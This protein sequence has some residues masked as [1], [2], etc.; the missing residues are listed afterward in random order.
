MFTKMYAQY[1]CQKVISIFVMGSIILFGGGCKSF[2]SRE[3]AVYKGEVLIRSVTKLKLSESEIVNLSQKAL[4]NSDA[5][6]AYTLFFYY[7]SLGDEDHVMWHAV[8]VALGHPLARA[9][10]FYD[11]QGRRIW[12]TITTYYQSDAEK[13]WVER[14]KK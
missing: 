8:A 4:Y 7:E 6:A 12:S 10:P 2:C 11:E 13:I 1:H 3:I 5:S 14:L 9:Q